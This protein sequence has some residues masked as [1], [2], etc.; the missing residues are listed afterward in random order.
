MFG[1][2]LLS[3]LISFYQKFL[4]HFSYGSCRYYPTCSEYAKLQYRGNSFFKASF[5]SF[6]RI[7]S[8]NQ[9]FQGGIDH[10]IIYKVNLNFSQK[11]KKIIFWLV[12]LIGEKN[13]YFI[14]KNFSKNI[15]LQNL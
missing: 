2:T 9:L 6:K 13:K 12:P 1:N 5:Y 7:L 4:T 8:C 11:P 3:N 10:P 15:Y 14:I